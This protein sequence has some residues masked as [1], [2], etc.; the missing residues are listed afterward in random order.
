M[1]Y[2]TNWNPPMVYD[3]TCTYEWD[4]PHAALAH[5][6]AIGDD[7]IYPARPWA[8]HAVGQVDAEAEFKVAWDETENLNDSFKSLASVYFGE[9]HI[10]MADPI[11]NWPRITERQ[12]GE[13]A[14]FQ[15]N[16]I[17]LGDLYNSQKMTFTHQEVSD[18]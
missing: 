1:A 4:V 5:E 16:I 6:G 7:F 17:D 8:D 2:I 9:F 12:S 18:G 13:I 3:R 15:R 11:W 14:G 10:A